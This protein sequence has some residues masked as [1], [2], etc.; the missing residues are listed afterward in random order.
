[1]C[2]NNTNYNFTLFNNKCYYLSTATGEESLNWFRARE[3]CQNIGS[4]LVSI[5]SGK[6]LEYIVSLVKIYYYYFCFIL[7][8][9]NLKTQK[10]KC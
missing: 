10:L 1:M 8:V 7:L 6:E 2:A 9:C 5:H 4:D 3:F